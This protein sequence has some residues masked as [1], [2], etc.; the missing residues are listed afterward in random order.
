[1]T[2]L[3]TRPEPAAPATEP[4]TLAERLLD[5][6]APQRPQSSPRIR[7]EVDGRVVEG[8]EG[9]TI[10]EVCRDNGIEI[11]TLCYEPKLP[12]FGACR[13]CVVEVE[14]EEHPP[15]SCSRTCEPEMK[16]QTQTEELRRLRRT[17]L[18]LIFSDHNAY[19]L[20]P[21]Q[22][23]CPSH[24]DIPGFLKANAEADWRE[25]ARIFKRT[26]PF[27]SILGR[28]CPAPCEEHCRRDEVDEAI[29]IRD[30]HRYAGDQVLKAML[31]DGV[32]PPLPFERQAPS[33]RRSA[34]IG[35]GPAGMSAAFYLL[36]AGHDVTV[37]ERDPAPGG[38]LRYGIPQYRLP[39]VEVLEAEYESVT[40]LGGKM[41]C[42]AALGCRLH[43]R[44]PDQPGL[45][46]GRRGDRLLRHEQAGD[47][48]RGRRR[49]HRR[50]RVPADGHARP[51]VPRSRRQAGRRH[52]RR[53][54]L[55][56][57]LADLGPAGRQGGDPRLSPRHEGHAGVERG[58]RGDRG[59]RHGHLPGRARPGHHR[60][61]R[62]T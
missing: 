8:F 17:N 33:G 61:R 2:D 25:S 21:C 47:P 34:V 5:T 24:I 59:R 42:N 18:E 28:V 49:V 57:L 32:D 53:V 58:P 12:G 48:R 37:F 43:A 16:V 51:A 62:A 38:M 54:H 23:K 50:P 39:K 10:L 3:I 52:R 7:I 40:R 4:E 15:I 44:R 55:D 9:Q 45:R 19:C 35:S 13:M 20:P 41:V 31:D 27:P 26:I 56:G 29:A 6:Q 1:M 30:S 36:L 22:N 46:F 60:R 14:G 11:P